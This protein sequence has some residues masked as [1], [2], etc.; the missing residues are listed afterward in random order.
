MKQD[1]SN[2]SER[3]NRLIAT[4]RLS[5]EKGFGWRLSSQSKRRQ[6]VHDE[7]HPEH[8]HSLERH[9][10]NSAGT[11]DTED[12]GDEVGRELELQELGD[13]VVDVAAPHHGLDYRAEVV[14]G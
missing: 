8:L 4:V 11:D 12:A 14:V 6:R 2:H 10:L 7:I 3:K 13:G 5:F 1:I 9:D